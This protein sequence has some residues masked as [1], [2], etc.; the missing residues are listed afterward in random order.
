MFQVSKGKDAVEIANF[1]QKVANRTSF[2]G[3]ELKDVMGIL[4]S[5]F[6]LHMQQVEL[7]NQTVRL[8]K[9]VVF[10]SC[11]SGVVDKLLVSKLGLRQLGEVSVL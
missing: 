4:I 9:S 3:H 7:Q 1:M 5:T 11:A 2:F 8:N 10:T 6:E